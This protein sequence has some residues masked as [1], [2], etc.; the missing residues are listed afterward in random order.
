MAHSTSR[1]VIAV[2]A[3][4]CAD[5]DGNPSIGMEVRRSV[6]SALQ[7]VGALPIMLALDD[8]ALIPQALDL[9]DGVVMPGGGDSDPNHYGQ[10]VKHSKL[11]QVAPEQDACDLALLRAALE[12]QLPILG[13]CRGMQ[14]LNIALGGDLLQHLDETDVAHRDSTHPI[15][16]CTDGSVV[17]QMMGSRRF[18][19]RS[20]HHQVLDR[21]A[22]VLRVTARTQ[23]GVVEAVEHREH[24]WVGVQWHP[25]LACATGP[26]QLGPF[27]WLVDQAAAR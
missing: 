19:G 6:A 11:N 21:V 9:V 4:F 16:V 8:P 25:E 14:S 13:I 12:R 20:L 23:D 26:V 18:D 1:P 15:E 7:A 5:P 24:P 10:A 22:D 2:A 17:E 3:R 27:R